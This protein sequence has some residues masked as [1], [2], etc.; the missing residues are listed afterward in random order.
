MPRLSDQE[1]QEVMRYLEADHP[2]PEKYCFLLFEDKRQME[3]V[4]NG[5][6]NTVCNVVL[7]F[8]TIEQLDEPRAELPLDAMEELQ[9]D[10]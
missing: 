3:L 8:Q 6:T 1:R 10:L 7:P 2:L 9:T 4:W 5:K